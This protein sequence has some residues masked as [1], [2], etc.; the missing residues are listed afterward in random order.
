[1]KFGW[2]AVTLAVR[3]DAFRRLVDPLAGRSRDG[4]SKV[5]CVSLGYG[6][7][8]LMRRFAAINRSEDQCSPA[9]KVEFVSLGDKRR[10]NCDTLIGSVV[11]TGRLKN[12]PLVT[13]VRKGVKRV[14]KAILK[15]AKRRVL[16]LLR[17]ACRALQD[18]NPFSSVI[19]AEAEPRL[20]TRNGSRSSIENVRDCCSNFKAVMIEPGRRVHK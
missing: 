11:A 9:Q 19:P 17:Q 1:M 12:R 16:A 20:S 8:S 14:L 10:S 15:T 5:P 3:V 6:T 4:N 2:S 18:R 7:S 13:M